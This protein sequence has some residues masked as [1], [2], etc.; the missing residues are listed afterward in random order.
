MILLFIAVVCIPIML[1]VK[2]FYLRFKHSRQ[3]RNAVVYVSLFRSLVS[4]D[5]FG[6]LLDHTP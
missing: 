4:V 5:S 1:L 3:S 6:S 2:P